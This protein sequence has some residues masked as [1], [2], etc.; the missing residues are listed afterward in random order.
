M[1]EAARVTARVFWVPTATFPKFKFDVLVSMRPGALTVS[2]A[3]LIWAV[4][5]EFVTDTANWVP[6]SD[7]FAAG[8]V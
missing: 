7:A 5:N 4:S 3:T 8:V 2:V 6:L 1:P